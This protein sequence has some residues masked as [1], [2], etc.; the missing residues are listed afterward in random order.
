MLNKTETK[1]RSRLAYEILGYFAA[2]AAISIFFFGFLSV[3]ADSIVISFC[4]SNNI[5]FTETQQWAVD[6]W[7]KGISQACAATIFVLLLLF[8]IGQKLSY[9]NEIT[10]GIEALQKHRMDYQIPVEGN[11]EL[12][13]L[14]ESIN[15]LSRTE[16]ELQLKES[17]MRE[18]REGLIRALSHDIRTPLTAILSYTE[19]MKSKDNWNSDEL[20]QFFS[21]TQQKAEQIK[22]L[23]GRLLD[24]SRTLE[25]I[26]DG[27]FF[28]EQLAEEWVYSIEEGFECVVDMSRCG[29][30]AAELDVQEMRRIFDNLASNVMK[31]ADHASPV[32]MKI[33]REEDRLCISQSNMI[34]E[35]SATVESSKIG[36]QSIEKIAQ[37]YGGAV[38]SHSEEGRFT[39]TIKL[40][41]II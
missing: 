14:A 1:K 13:E 25:K 38:S 39:V 37:Q 15:F 18:E 31:Y 17:L 26:E 21:M 35:P 22:E 23:T 12:T 16:R 2:T 34:C 19:Y 40:M 7:I 41:K 9:L 27:K 20:N 29:S 11:N 24:G 10:Q 5:E 3:T 30:F 4:D 8:L 28:M 6:L 33:F 36:L 32:E